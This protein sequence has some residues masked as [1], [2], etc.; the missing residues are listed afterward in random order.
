MNRFI[1]IRDFGAQY[2]PKRTKTYDMIAT[3]KIQAVKIGPR[4][5]ITRESAERWAASLPRFTPTP[6]RGD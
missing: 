4:T 5:M 3:G 1:S 2:G 6:R